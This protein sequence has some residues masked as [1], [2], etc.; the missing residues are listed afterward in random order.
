MRPSQSDVRSDIVSMLNN[1]ADLRNG[2]MAHAEVIFMEAMKMAGD[3]RDLREFVIEY[4]LEPLCELARHDNYLARKFITGYLQPYLVEEGDERMQKTYIMSTLKNFSLLRESMASPELQQDMGLHIVKNLILFSKRGPMLELE[5]MRQSL[6][7]IYNGLL[8][9]PAA[10]G[11]LLQ[12]SETLALKNDAMPEFTQ[13]LCNHLPAVSKLRPDVAQVMC[14]LLLQNNQQAERLSKVATAVTDALPIIAR[15]EPTRVIRIIEDAIEVMTSMNVTNSNR[16]ELIEQGVRVAPAV[17][18]VSGLAAV[19]MIRALRKL[20]NE[21]PDKA[22]IYKEFTVTSPSPLDNTQS[23]IFA[24]EEGDKDLRIATTQFSGLMKTFNTKTS[25]TSLPPDEI[26]H[27]HEIAHFADFYGD[28][29][30]RKNAAPSLSEVF[31]SNSYYR[32]RRERVDAIPYPYV[33]PKIGF[34]GI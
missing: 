6:A 34:H 33:P 26:A 28:S 8:S 32:H 13:R 20:A 3:D 31:S 15:S 2:G 17:A 18:K 27:R 9:D 5:F 22:G 10:S 14:R 16:I 11:L 4:A 29:I 23:V 1:F 21:D 24:K 12:L 7:Q 25:R 19:Y 30:M